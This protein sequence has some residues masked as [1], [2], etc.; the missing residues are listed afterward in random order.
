MSLLS[1]LLIIAYITYII[2]I[3]SQ[4]Y[5]EDEQFFVENN[6]VMLPL[7]KELTKISIEKAILL[8]R[9]IRDY[10]KEPIPIEKLSMILWSAQGITNPQLRFR[11]APSA[12]ATYPLEIYLVVGNNGL[13]LSNNSYLPAGIYK[14][15][16]L[17]HSIILLKRG[18][19]RED[20]A[21]EALN[22]KWVRKAPI[23]IV[24]CGVYERTTSR[25]GERGIRYV[26]IEVGHVGQNIYLMSTALGLGTVAVGAFHDNG[27]AR[28]ISAEPN[29]HPLYI[30]PIGIPVKPYNISF[31]E[32]QRLYQE[33]RR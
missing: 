33:M 32:I 9:S 3:P 25:Y 19:H 1:I 2:N 23:S 30:M 28:V 13:V 20:L 11:A 27:V 10:K 6:E 26:H 8:R 18:D 7:P 31:Q 5:L 22:Q 17:R 29:E 24:I 12:G 4:T 14:Y 15:N 16:V 21:K